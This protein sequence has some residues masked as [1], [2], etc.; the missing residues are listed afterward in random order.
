MVLSWFQ[1][2]QLKPGSG[3]ASSMNLAIAARIAMQS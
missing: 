2:N 1:K 3:A